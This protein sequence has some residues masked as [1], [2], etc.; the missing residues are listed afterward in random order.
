MVM[1]PSKETPG[2]AG[3]W[4]LLLLQEMESRKTIGESGDIVND[5][6]GHVPFASSKMWHNLVVET[7]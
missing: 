6:L 2:M 1:T 7:V 4:T 5:T 3:M